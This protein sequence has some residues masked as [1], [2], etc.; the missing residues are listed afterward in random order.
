MR[1]P[2]A[3]LTAAYRMGRREH[4]L[5]VIRA[6][7]EMVNGVILSSFE[8]MTLAEF[9][10]WASQSGWNFWVNNDMRRLTICDPYPTLGPDQDHGGGQGRPQYCGIGSDG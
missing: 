2:L 7:T 1:G 5:N 9:E 8:A 3:I 4:N 6:V 10:A